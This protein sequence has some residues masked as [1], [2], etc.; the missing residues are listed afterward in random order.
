MEILNETTNNNGTK[1][2][3]VSGQFEII[4]SHFQSL[5]PNFELIQKE[6]GIFIVR[7][8]SDDDL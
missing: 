1:T 2:Y 6:D 8:L 4:M 5:L 7:E 3:E